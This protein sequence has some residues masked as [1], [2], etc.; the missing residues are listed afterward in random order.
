[1]MVLLA[2]EN[3]KN[4][5]SC[6]DG[7]LDPDEDCDTGNF[8][9]GTCGDFGFYTQT[10]ELACTD[11]CTLAA[12]VCTGF[13]GDDDVQV[14]SGE[15]CEGT[16]LNGNTCVSLGYSGG[17]LTCQ[18]D[19]KFDNSGCNSTCGN[20]VID[21]EETC[22]D[23]N[24]IDD[25]GCSR[26]CIQEDGYECTG[27]PST[28]ETR[29]GDGIAAGEEACDGADL[30]GFT[31][32]DQGYWTGTF[33]C[34][35]SCTL[36]NA[37]VGVRQLV[38]GEAHTCALLTD[39]T[40][41]C[42]GWNLYGQLGDGTGLDSSIPVRIAALEDQAASVSAGAWHTCAVKLD[43]SLWCWGRNDRGQLGVGV[44]E[45]RLS[46]VVIA[47]LVVGVAQVSCGY[48]HTCI[49]SNDGSA[50][51][52]GAND[53]GQ[54][55][56]GTATDSPSPVQVSGFGSEI[57]GISAGDEFTC[58]RKVDGSP[59]CW[60]RN[61]LGQLGDGT[62]TEKSRPTPPVGLETGLTGMEVGPKHACAYYANSDLWCWGFNGQGQT[63]IGDTN[64]RTTPVLVSA[65]QSTHVACGLAH[66]CAVVDTQVRC[67]GGNEMGQL[68]DGT[69]EEH[70]IPVQ[71]V[72]LSLPVLLAAG[73]AHTCAVLEVGGVRCWGW[74]LLGQLG[75][76]TVID[77][78]TPVAV[79]PPD[80]P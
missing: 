80:L 51:C 41:W 21:T 50:S 54:L 72:E 14:S 7:V 70:L 57:A 53:F 49:I 18:A 77:S 55:G 12:G 75:D 79:T 73:N 59:F 25:D 67:W 9:F 39:D 61:D 52:W 17:L 46:P 43:G 19:C 27:T 6:G 47:D 65:V 37:C 31:C 33:S 68:G 71:T 29:C 20:G 28:C 36:V 5:D 30:R 58:A 62:L 3:V 78:T 16:D 63:G 69:N 34:T 74:N 2:C 10:G 56:N 22:D 24:R 48:G 23:G 32:I 4:V 45:D 8:R 38:A 76:G 15:E 13:C 64:T 40:L 44:T 42:W 60:G 1:M 35:D 26:L 11:Q 66:T